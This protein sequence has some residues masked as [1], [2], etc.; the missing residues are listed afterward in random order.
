[1]IWNL[2][3]IRHYAVLSKLFPHGV[4][5]KRT[6]NL[7]VSN[8]SCYKS[9]WKSDVTIPIFNCAWNFRELTYFKMLIL[10]ELRTSGKEHLNRKVMPK[11]HK[12]TTQIQVLQLFP[13]PY[14][15]YKPVML[16]IEQSCLFC[17]TRCN[18]TILKTGQWL[19]PVSQSWHSQ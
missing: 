1:M 18:H 3:T 4:L 8:S 5:W 19:L 13:S 16:L 9:L 7:N 12:Y 10:T 6:I 17:K 14:Q 2:G 15:H 11:D